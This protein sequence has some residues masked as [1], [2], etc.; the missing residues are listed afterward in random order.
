MT[1][2]WIG[3]FIGALFMWTMRLVLDIACDRTDTPEEQ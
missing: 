3:L 1:L 2:F